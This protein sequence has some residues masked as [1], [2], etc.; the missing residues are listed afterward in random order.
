MRRKQSLTRIVAVALCVCMVFGFLPTFAVEA[1]AIGTNAIAKGD[2]IDGTNY[3]VTSVKNYS[4]A[5]DITERVIITN[6]SSGSSQTVANVMEVNTSNGNAKIVTGYGNRNP[7]QEGWTL[8]TTTYQADLYEKETGENVVGGVN[9][10]WFNI[11]T[12]EP[13]G[14]LVINGTVHHDNASK[15]YVAAFSDGSVNVFQAGTTLEQA[16]AQQSEKVGNPVTV[17]EAVDGSATL[18]W[19]GEPYDS[20]GNDGAYSRT[21]VGIKEDGTV[22]LFQADG[23]MAP[24]STGYTVMEEA[25]MMVA[26]GCVYAIRL[27]EGGSSTYVSQHEGEEKVTM[28]NTPAGGSERV[29]SGSILVVST[30]ASS[31]E[32]DHAAITPNAEYFTPDS[33]IELTAT[34]MDYSGADANSLPE[35]ATFT[36]AEGDGTISETIH[37]G[38]TATATFVASETTGDVTIQMVSGGSVVGTAVLHIQDPDS[39][40]FTSESIALNY[41]AESNLG[42]TATYQNEAVRLKDGDIAWSIT[43]ETAGTFDGLKFIATSAT[44]YSGSPTVTAKYGDLTAAVIV[45]IGKEPLYILDGGDNDGLDYSTI[46]YPS[47]STE[48]YTN[49]DTNTTENYEPGQLITY[50]YDKRGGKVSGSVVSDSDE[51]YADIIRFGTNAI[52]L[53]YDWSEITGTDGVCVGTSDYYYVTG[54]PTA[55]GVWVY[56]EEGSPIPWLRTQISTSTDGGQSWTNAYCNFTG[57]SADDKVVYGW[58]Y[59]E[60]DLTQYAGALIRINKGQWFRAMVTTGGIGWYDAYGNKMDKSELQGTL[61]IDNFCIVY[62]ANNQDTKSPEVTSISTFNEDGTKTEL[63]DGTAF[64]SGSLRFYVTYDDFENVDPHA[65]GIE[66]AYFYFDGVYYGRYDRDNLGSTSYLMHFG[67]GQHSITFYL[68][69]GNGNVTRETRYFT[70]EEASENLPNI[71][72]NSNGNPEVGKEWGLYLTGDDLAQITQLSTTISISKIYPVTNVLFPD[73][74]TGTYTYTSAKGLLNIEITSID[75]AVFTSDKLAEI[76]VDVPKAT[77]EGASILVQVTRGSYGIDRDVDVGEVNQLVCGFSTDFVSYAVD[78]AYLLKADLILKGQQGYATVSVNPSG[79]PAANVDI[80]CDG[81]YIGT[82]DENGQVDISEL[83]TGATS[84]TLYAKDAE[85]NYS[86][87]ITAYCYATVGDETGAPYYI[88]SNIVSNADSEK[89]ISWMSNPDY[90]TDKAEIVLSVSEDMSNSWTVEGKSTLIPYSKDAVVNRVNSVYVTGL[91]AGTT[92]YYQVGDGTVMSEIQSFTTA[93]ADGSDVTFFLLA[94]IQEED[95]LEGMKTI[96]SV[97]KDRDYDFGVQLGDAVD[98]VRYYSQWVDTLDLFSLEGL[99]GTNFLHVVG[100]HEADDDGNHAQAAMN[101]FNLK[102]MWYSFEYGDVYVA[103]LNH[104]TDAD[105]LEAFAEW[106]TADAARSNATWKVLMTHV[107][108]YY[109]N[110]TGGGAIYQSALLDAIDAAGIDFYFAANDHSYAR[111]AAMTGGEKNENGTVYYIC[112]STGGKSYS[113]VNNPAFNFEVATLEFDHVYMDVT[114]DKYQ[115]TITAYNIDDSGNVSVLDTYTARPVDVCE[116]DEHTYIYDRSTGI[117][118]CDVCGYSCSATEDMYS[119]YVADRETGRLMYLVAGIA[120]TGYI[121]DGSAHYYFDKSGLG[122]EG[123]Y[124]IGGETVTFHNGLYVSSDNNDVV[125]AGMAGDSAYFVMYTDGTFRV[126]GSGAMYSYEKTASIP[127]YSVIK[128]IKAIEISSE[129]TSIGKFSFNPAQNCTSVTFAEDSQLKEVGAYAFAHMIKLTQII[130]PD[131]VATI[132][133]NAFKDDPSLAYV[134]MPD[135]VSTISSTA[136]TSCNKNI[137]VLSVAQDSPAQAY[138]QKYSI[139][140]KTRA[141]KPIYS[142]SCGNGTTWELYNSGRLVISGNGAMEDY[143]KPNNAPWYAYRSK[144]TDIE[145]GAGITCIGSY[146]FYGT[147][148]TNVSFA[149]GSELTKIGSYA[150]YTDSALTEITLPEKLTT[151]NS[152]AFARCTGLTSVYLPDGVSSIHNKAFYLCDTEKLVLNVGNASPALSFAKTYGYRYVERDPVVL[153]SGTIGENLTW[154]LTSDGIL[155]IAGNGA[156]EDYAKPNNAPWY[157]YRSKITN[158]EIGAG[159]TYIGNYAFYGTKCTNVSFAEGSELTKIGSY[160][161]YTDSALTEITL[162]EKL[163]TINSFAFARCTGLTSVY[164]PDGVSSIHNKAFYLCDTEKLV[165]NV[166]AGSYAESWAITNG[167]VHTVYNGE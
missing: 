117:L 167:V 93:E 98:N 137:L 32:F 54:T 16:E 94:D 111:T 150:F 131:T 165:L 6:N 153:Y 162:P 69:D 110:P 116:N 81:T 164:L 158:I 31:G 113:V 19:D 161:F 124:V 79:E 21:A 109:T 104:T 17:V 99:A 33:E 30:V 62:G 118:T 163:T 132:G 154:A 56:I 22:V 91:S 144:I 49:T 82:T 155:K 105:N 35:D 143:A 139:Q 36:V 45:E 160:A 122:Y 14:Y 96:G 43:D 28:R 65:T 136:F 156:M 53:D 1:S 108:V 141:A 44:T 121:T 2:S 128:N 159:I 75:H 84:Y 51:T 3:Y 80:Y 145:I 140:Y 142:G 123:D 76:I 41:G 20:G 114:A 74:V 52:K 87:T 58:Q 126:S 5:P 146:A 59:F 147:K 50:H 138:A 78:A 120:Q 92:Y 77:A 95:A 24:R 97:L 66:S 15:G 39:L 4:I 102:D 83:N 112:G 151:I 106:L 85:E 55:L 9:A 47:T 71:T 42:L 60:A 12:G 119:G 67:K 101:I 90:S 29:I 64:Q 148:C 23:T 129:I 10:S 26:L 63:E 48:T 11:N 107:P 130:L 125:L 157:A 68:K 25:K 115:I 152:F 38:A 135:A 103:V 149:E 73:G 86:Y 7:S 27:D 13:S 88:L 57:G 34:A 40:S 134:Y 8:K 89:N 46:I 133:S 100:N 127:W 37:N 70:V 72:L 61:I 18:V 166:A